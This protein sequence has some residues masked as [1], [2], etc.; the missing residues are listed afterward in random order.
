MA[1][2]SSAIPLR[3][4]RPLQG[5]GNYPPSGTARPLA[6]WGKADLH[7]HSAAGDGLASPAE[8]LQYVQEETDLDLIAI[9][10]HD[11]IEGA[12]EARRLVEEGD[13]RFDFLVGMEI[14]TLEGHILAYGI[15]ERIGMLQPL[16]RTLQQVHAQGGFVVIPHPMS[17]L[18]RSL[19]RRGILRVARSTVPGVH[20]DG[21]EVV[22]PS[23][24]GKVVY[25]QV[26]DLNQQLGL[27]ETAGSDS[28]TLDT[29]GC[30]YTRFP[31]FTGE[32]FRRALAARLT[33]A[34]G[35]FWGIEEH[36]RLVS[37]AGRQVF[38]SWVLLPGQHI[39]RGLQR[40]LSVQG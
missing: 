8:I 28:H 15:Q 35:E 18:T 5:L 33:S 40:L 22:N 37:I 26:L 29:I 14:T 7:I 39:R 21:I 36:R 19:G 9:T 38:R 24:A 17:W 30:V 6:R 1:D 3:G 31:G 20:F 32:D 23:I 13:Y 34:V 27:G 10:D 16:A 2:R 12:L 25:R 4:L 11:L